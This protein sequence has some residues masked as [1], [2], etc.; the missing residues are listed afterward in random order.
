MESQRYDCEFFFDH[1]DFEKLTIC[2]RS[3]TKHNLYERLRLTKVCHDKMTATTF[4]ILSSRNSIFVLGMTATTSTKKHD[5][6]LRINYSLSLI[7]SHSC[8][9]DVDRMQFYSVLE[10]LFLER[11]NNTRN[12]SGKR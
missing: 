6:K 3:I 7:S 1:K 12:S 4:G 10:T 8:D 11:E 2:M 9:S 5:D